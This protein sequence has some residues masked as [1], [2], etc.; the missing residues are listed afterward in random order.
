MNQLAIPTMN[1]PSKA[2]ADHGA[3]KLPKITR[4]LRTAPTAPVSTRP[5]AWQKTPRG[6][7]VATDVEHLGR[8]KKTREVDS[9]P[10]I[11]VV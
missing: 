1:P 4:Q 5:S 11:L 9:R 8:P 2:L 10:L 7:M 6:R 3:S